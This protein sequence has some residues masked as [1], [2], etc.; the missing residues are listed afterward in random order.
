MKKRD[1]EAIYDPNVNYDL[2]EQHTYSDTPGHI[3]YT[4]PRC[5]HEYLAT[6]ITNENGKIMCTE[7]AENFS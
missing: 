6:F 7:C 3:F 2:L 1:S 5:G 4:C